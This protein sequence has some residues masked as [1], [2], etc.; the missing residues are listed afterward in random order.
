VSDTAQP[1]TVTRFSGLAEDYHRY[2][3]GYPA[4]ALAAV[5]EGLAPQPTA[6]DVGAGTGISTQALIAAGAHAI[7]IEPNDEMRAVALASGLDARPGTATAT[8]LA[9]GC[10]D[11]VASFQ[12]FHWFA[13]AGALAEFL[14]LL[15]PGGRVALVWNERNQKDPFSRDFRLLEKR[16]GEAAMLAGA[17]FVDEMLE[18]LLRNAG[19][20]GVRRVLFENSQVL[21]ADSL[22]GR[23]RSCSYAPRSG[24]V[25][26]EL[27]AEL[28]AL[29][30]T[31][32]DAAGQVELR[33]LTE[34]IM[35]DLVLK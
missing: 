1:Q 31:Y 17:D 25:Y 24:P 23:V 33:Y 9:D 4:A 27:L 12:A 26:D 11:L 35:G 10:A 18:P 6:I 20:S 32:A 16:F 8:G 7:A 15:R 28:A 5:L 2:R 29:H 14:R 22:V 30:R 21:N 19:L 13:N 3:P 34:V